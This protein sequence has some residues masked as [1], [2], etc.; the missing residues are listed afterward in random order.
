MKTFTEA[1]ITKKNIKDVAA[2][3][4]ISNVPELNYEKA[5]REDAKKLEKFL[6]ANNL[7]PENFNNGNIWDMPVN[8]ERI[9]WDVRIGEEIEDVRDKGAY[10]LIFTILGGPTIITNSLL[11]FYNGYMMSMTLAGRESRR[12][13]EETG[14]KAI[15]LDDYFNDIADLFG[16]EYIELDAK[17]R[18][19]F[20]TD[21]V[22]VSPESPAY[23][24][25]KNKDNYV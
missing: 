4:S 12:Y 8:G 7:W 11:I 1:F 18:K 10:F 22:W 2:K 9:E 5:T 21:G 19:E 6:K 17:Q 15:D 14:P 16:Y 24:V 13:V 25:L 3:S 20:N 23:N